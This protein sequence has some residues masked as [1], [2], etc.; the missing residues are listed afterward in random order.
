MALA[1]QTLALAWGA[2]L[3]EQGVPS[4][5]I[6]N[7]YFEM[8]RSAGS[9]M[10]G[11][12]WGEAV[13]AWMRV[14]DRWSVA[15]LDHVLDRLLSADIALKDTRVSTDQ[16]IISTLVLEICAIESGARARAA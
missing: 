10:T 12:P 3:R 4:A 15:A 7:D 1:V 5:R 11:R 6:R 2:A 14:V 9:L 16:Q 8:L 13:D